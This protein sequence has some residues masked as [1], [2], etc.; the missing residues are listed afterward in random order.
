MAVPKDVVTRFVTGLIKDKAA[1]VSVIKSFTV[2]FNPNQ[3]G[4]YKTTYGD[5]HQ[6]NQVSRLGTLKKKTVYGLVDRKQ[7]SVKGVPLGSVLGLRVFF[8]FRN[9]SFL[10]SY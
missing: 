8:Q 9:E 2:I 5:C 3:G 10:K 4:W 1:G 7:S 6:R